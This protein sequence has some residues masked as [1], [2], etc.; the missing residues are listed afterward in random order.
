[1]FEYLMPGLWMRAYP[2]TMLTQTKIA[3]VET[4]QDTQQKN[5]FRGATPN[6]RMRASKKM[7]TMPTVLS[8]CRN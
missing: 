8:E 1:M 3:A 6:R 7:A 4:Q 5:V 2:Q